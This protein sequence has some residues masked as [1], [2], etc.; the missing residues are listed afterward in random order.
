MES[1][2]PV[3]STPLNG[4][5]P[6]GKW[7]FQP[8]SPEFE[9]EGS[10]RKKLFDLEGQDTAAD[11]SHNEQQWSSSSEYFSQSVNDASCSS[12]ES[13]TDL[14]GEN[15]PPMKSEVVNSYSVSMI[16]NIATIVHVA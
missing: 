7:L 15:S 11:A 6:R 12:V 8:C 5:A 16:N 13:H 4:V 1:P 14:F 9:G 10:V 2:S 3:P